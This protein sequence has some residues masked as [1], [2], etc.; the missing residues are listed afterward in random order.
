MAAVTA[1][2]MAIA[3]KLQVAFYDQAP[4][5]TSATVYCGALVNFTVIGRLTDATAAA[6]RR[7]A[8]MLVQV[9]NDSGAIVSAGTGNAG[10]TVLGLFRYNNEE[11][12]NVKT[13]TRTTTNL[14]KIV[15]VADNQTVAGTS[16]GTAG[17]RVAVGALNQFLSASDKTQAWI[18]LRHLSTT[19][20]ANT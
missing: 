14:G 18:A 15:L 19:D 17:V 13:S 20:V 12:L 6:S 7:F 3:R 2:R 9:L 5:A 1:E 10:G 16:V 11:L 4:I 8:G